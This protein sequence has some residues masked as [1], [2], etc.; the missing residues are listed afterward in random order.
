VFGFVL[1]HLLLVR[2]HSECLISAIKEAHDL[3]EK[4]CADEESKDD[5]MLD[6]TVDGALAKAQDAA[7]SHL[8]PSVPPLP[9]PL[10]PGPLS[11]SPAS[12]HG[13]ILSVSFL[14]PYYVLFAEAPSPAPSPS[15]FV[16]GLPLGPLT[17][18]VGDMDGNVLDP[19]GESAVPGVH[20]RLC[21]RFFV[22]TL[23]FFSAG[24]VKMERFE[25]WLDR[26]NFTQADYKDVERAINNRAQYCGF[27]LATS[28]HP[29]GRA[30]LRCT[31]HTPAVDSDASRSHHRKVFSIP[32]SLF[33]SCSHRYPHH[34]DKK[35][36]GKPRA[37]P[38]APKPAAVETK[39]VP[40]A[41]ADAPHSI[42]SAPSD[43]EIK[44]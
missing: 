5:E 12:D 44:V 6:L 20:A 38:D 40:H 14:M 34:Q 16:A 8:P 33:I 2:T 32:S 7:P 36:K 24:P 37:E 19:V 22:L 15:P 35:K 13:P 11:R 39:E 10:P 26:T 27:Q 42:P 25:R 9:L 31:R 30:Y 3:I 43:H 4:E 18:D 17:D 28:S 41:A 21:L 29:E 1:L 23:S